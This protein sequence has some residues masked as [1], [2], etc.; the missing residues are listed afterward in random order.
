MYKYRITGETVLFK[1]QRNS[2]QR[3]IRSKIIYSA[4]AVAFCACAVIYIVFFWSSQKLIYDTDCESLYS[5]IKTAESALV[6]SSENVYESA[7]MWASAK[8]VSDFFSSAKS[9]EPRYFASG[10][11]FENH[12]LNIAAVILKNG[13][14]KY[15]V[16]Y[17]YAN[18][19]KT[20]VYTDLSELYSSLLADETKRI[21]DTS[22]PGSEQE[23]SRTHGFYTK[24]GLVFYAAAAPVFSDGNPD[25]F[26]GILVFVRII[27]S[28]YLQTLKNETGTDFE[29]GTIS[30]LPLTSEQKN[31][32]SVKKSLISVQ[33][34]TITFY[35]GIIDI[36]SRTSMYLSST[37]FRGQNAQQ[38]RQAMIFLPVI[39]LVCFLILIVIVLQLIRKI[40]VKPLETLIGDVNSID[41]DSPETVLLS[42]TKNT[43]FED[44]KISINQML[45]RMK[46][47][48]DII[49]RNN[50]RL[51]HQANFDSLTGLR[52]RF[53]IMAELDEMLQTARKE[54]F[55]VS[56]F[57]CNID[58]FK[59][60]NDTMGHSTG[61]LL[62]Q[63]LS[64][65]LKGS[66]DESVE[67]SRMG[68]DEFLIAV[69][70][71]DMEQTKIEIINKIINIYE[72]PFFVGNGKI[73]ISACFGCATFPRDG[74]N[75]ETLVKHAELA[76]FRAKELGKGTYIRYTEAIQINIE[77]KNRIESMLHDAIDSGFAGFS[78]YFQPELDVS[79]KMIIGCEA[80]LRWETADGVIPPGIFIPQA[81]ESDLI[82]PL[83][84]WMIKECIRIGREF[85]RRGINLPIAI[86]A[87]SQ[88][89]LHE[90][91]LLLLEN[92]YRESPSDTPKL[93][94]EIVEATLVE[95]MNRINKIIREL[96]R[97][98][99]DISVDD[100]GTGYS[101]LS[102]LNKISVDR[103]K[104]DRSFVQ[105]IGRNI[106]DQTIINAIIA[107][108]KSMKMSVIAEGVETIDQYTFLENADCDEIQGYFVS[109]ALPAEKFV[110]FVKNW[111]PERTF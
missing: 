20:S 111:S 11:L 35:S 102:Y 30:G 22:S 46:T 108:A 40:M 12:R 8:E 63:A 36:D 101:S 28:S 79:T 2:S 60:I 95:D 110:E 48:R 57:Y 17:D 98:N 65:R 6:S 67:I 32:L 72:T 39:L 107:I 87:S 64:S 96:H 91:F 90:E 13:T 109:E 31:E 4:A 85:V 14:V 27:N 97:L 18:K 59:Y 71:S 86:N 23:L 103:I 47:S 100:F 82:L 26:T 7:R 73:Q 54:S 83:S 41:L 77:Q 62:L 104:I 84:W 42:D 29:V 37:V 58:R 89:L 78:A 5:N 34:N 38:L 10:S 43:E 45:M 106:G 69:P 25:S 70:R 19:E 52:N 99:I 76:K 68:G 66:F 81:E 16:C 74:D 55:A 44:L 51:Y 24:D 15:E 21:Q 3:S 94:I 75:A 33:R 53:S 105:G 80:L 92:A 88:V 50:E 56:V 61:D 93:S 49:K 9:P 1:T